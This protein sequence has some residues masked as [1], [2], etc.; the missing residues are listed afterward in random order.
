MLGFDASDVDLIIFDEFIPEAHERPIKNEAAALFNAYE[1]I[2]RNRELDGAAPC[3]LLCLANANDLGN[4]VF[5]ELGLV[6]KAESMRRKGQEVYIDPKRGIC[7]I[8]L[9]KSPISREKTAT[10][11]YKLAKDGEYS[12]MA[13]GNTFAGAGENRIHSI[14]LQ[15]LV[16][17]V[18]V[19]E[20]TA[21][22]IKGQKDYY[23][24]THPSGNPPH[25]GTGPS[26]LRPF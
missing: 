8:I 4:P 14:P 2:N 12:Q 20:L 3:Q 21:Y 22:R 19:G 1:T 9:Q 15:Q 26:A 23:F 13:I 18:T 11:L 17:V 7:M 25:Y 10:A 24:C 16:P 6:R 5:L